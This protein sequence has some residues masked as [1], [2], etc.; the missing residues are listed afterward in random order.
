MSRSSFAFTS[1]ALRSLH[2]EEDLLDRQRYK[3][4][5]GAPHLNQYL[6]KKEL[7]W[8]EEGNKKMNSVVEQPEVCQDVVVQNAIFTGDL[9]TLKQLFPKGTSVNFVI[10]SRGEDLRWISNKFGLWSLTYEQELTTPLHITASRGY[11]DCLKHLLMR[12]SEV[13]IAPG[14]RT[15]LHD[16]CSNATTECAKLLLTYGASANSVTEDGFMPLHLCTTP[17]SFQC[18]KLLLQFGAHVNGCSLDDDDTPLHL[19]A[20]YGLEEH[21]DLYL[22]YGAAME[23]LNDEG[24]TP[25]NAACSQPHSA[26]ELERYY[27]I[28]KRLVEAGANIFTSDQDKQTPLHMACK[29]VNPKVVEL[30]L[31]KGSNVN[32]MSYS[33]NAPMHN[34]LKGVAFKLEHQPEL[35][36]RSL[37]NYGSIR[38][39]PEAL[40]KVLKYCCPSPRTIEALMNAY[41]RLKITDAWLE[42]VSPE[43]FQKHRYFYE[44][45]F[46][47]ANRPRSLQH[48]VR[49]KL[50]KYLEGRLHQAVPK[51][52][53]PTF[54]QNYL[55]LHF[56]DCLH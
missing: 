7:R 19:A 3:R 26:E 50:R 30:L 40:P 29:N 21:V 49:C 15:A 8:K 16:A 48:L 55:L 37:L 22:R 44:S 38:V 4:R 46:A 31:Q 52:G 32:I 33:S 35:I 43:V 24:Q 51:L 13:D 54:L 28:C 53:L 56:R 12:G 39:W 2:L 14:G 23:K 20:R 9:D 27:H 17:Q 6:L 10:E 42:A 34:I 25:L 11:T 5:L 41:D 18:A 1:T 36:V 45:L 47:L